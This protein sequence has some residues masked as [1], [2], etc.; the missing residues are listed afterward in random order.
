MRPQDSG[1]GPE[2]GGPVARPY[3][4]TGGRTRPRGARRLDL[5]DLVVRGPGPAA[6]AP[7]SPE[8]ARILGLCESPASVAEIAAIVGLPLGVIRVLLS[9]M[10][11]ENLIALAGT[12]PQGPVTDRWL[13]SRVLEGLRAL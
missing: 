2:K 11:D 8:R 7:L 10:A 4:V 6:G 5:A 1:W 9:D 13:L 12:A 3:T